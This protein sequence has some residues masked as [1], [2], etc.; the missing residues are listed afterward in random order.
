[1]LRSATNDETRNP[2]IARHEAIQI[3]QYSSGLLR[4]ARNDGDLYRHHS[5]LH[6]IY[7]MPGATNDEFCKHVNFSVLEK[8]IFSSGSRNDG[9]CIVITLFCRGFITCPL[10]IMTNLVTPSLRGTK[11]SRMSDFYYGFSISK[12]SL[13][14]VKNSSLDTHV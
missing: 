11:Q 3:E 1:M 6:G 2:V 10:L 7:P 14:C 5:F 9:D 12:K 8:N 4:S 13:L